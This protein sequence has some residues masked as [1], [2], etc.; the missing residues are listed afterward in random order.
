MRER[1]RER[2]NKRKREGREGR[3]KEE[4]IVFFIKTK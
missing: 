2:E 4:I 1:T 3:K